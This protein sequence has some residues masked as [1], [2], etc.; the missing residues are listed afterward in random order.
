MASDAEVAMMM[1]MICR[2]GKSSPEKLA[3]QQ[4]T[5]AVKVERALQ[6]SLRSWNGDSEIHSAYK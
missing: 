3:E 2:R 5:A 4:N 1:M 6:R